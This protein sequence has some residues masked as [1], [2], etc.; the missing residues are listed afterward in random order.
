MATTQES[1]ACTL[2]GSLD[3]NIEGPLDALPGCNPITNG[4]EPSAYPSGSCPADANAK[5]LGSLTG[6]IKSSGAK[7]KLGGNVSTGPNNGNT[8]VGSGIVNNNAPSPSSASAAPVSS[9]STS[10]SSQS[11]GIGS[12][13]PQNNGNTAANPQSNGNTNPQMGAPNAQML[14]EMAAGNKRRRGVRRS[15]R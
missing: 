1:E 7:G 14:A 3:E 13:N 6:P 8:N 5:V 2:P 9:S 4:P 11:T 12:T 10:A 15:L